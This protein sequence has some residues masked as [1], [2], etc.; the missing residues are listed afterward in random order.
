MDQ[1]SSDRSTARG[2][3]DPAALAAGGEALYY[4]DAAAADAAVA[5]IEGNFVHVIGEWAGRPIV[6][7]PWERDD[8][9]RPIFGWKRVADNSRRYRKASIWV[10]RKNG[11]T[12][13]AAILAVMLLAADGE[14]GAEIYS[15]ANDKEQAKICY[16]MAARMVE[17]S[18]PL[19]EVIEVYESGMVCLELGASFR[20]RSS[21]AATAHGTNPHGVIADELHEFTS[22]GLLDAMESGQGARRQPLTVT[23]STAGIYDK[24]TPGW[25]EYDY[26]CK[27]RDG[28]IDDPELLVV[29]YEAGRD[30]D[31]TAEATWRKANPN[32]GIT[33][34][35]AF[36]RAECEKA[37][38]AP[39]LINRFKRL[40][41]NQ[42]TE[43][44]TR[45]IALSDWDACAGETAWQD[46][47]D[48]LADR[49]DFYGGL[50]V[51]SRNDTAAWL[52]VFPPLEDPQGSP[53]DP[54]IWLPRVFIP[55]ERITARV[56][57]DRVPYDVWRDAGALTATDGNIIDQNYIKRAI[58]DD[59][60][61]W[62]CR[63]LAY[64]RYDSTKLALELQDEGLPMFGFAQGPLS[65]N[66]PCRTLG[67]EHVP[68]RLL[69][70][71]GHPVLAWQISNVMVRMD[72]NANIKP[73][74]EK[75]IEKIDGVVAGLMGLGCALT[76]DEGE[77][78][79]MSAVWIG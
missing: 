29:T 33:V 11:K 1:A 38:R 77:E 31:W 57:R 41:C 74:K 24:T 27:V 5:A 6:L 15:I 62:H 44:E 16:A 70:H 8:I 43:A 61:R 13:L 58:L 73:D 45:W 34:K 51:A 4:F 52:L 67:E 3:P 21:K 22:R 59:C 20:P 18:A 17:A 66:P 23:I 40:Y 50:D 25:Q 63:K 7:E 76:D 9:V 75:S 78:A 10:A 69:A 14:P 56:E 79:P 39:W 68:G 55:N 30:D 26:A 2:T 19:S 72:S 35:P 12:T 37:Q 53:D 42:W 36:L 64:D 48:S 65:F 46:L 32:F 28:V 47:A 60:E 54:W 49:R 71:G